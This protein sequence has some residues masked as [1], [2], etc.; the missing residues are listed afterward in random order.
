LLL[1][2]QLCLFSFFGQTFARRG[3]IYH[4]AKNTL[5]ALLV[6]D[7]CLTLHANS[8]RAINQRK[9]SDNSAAFHDFGIH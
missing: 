6:L 3:L 5:N 7:L 1:L 2:S 8:L 4:H 9:D